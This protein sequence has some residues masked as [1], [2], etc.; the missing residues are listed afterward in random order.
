LKLI[1]KMNIFLNFTI[2][3]RGKQV[4]PPEQ[5]SSFHFIICY[6]Q[7]TPLAYFIFIHHF[8]KQ[9]WA[10]IQCLFFFV[11]KNVTIQLAKFNGTPCMAAASACIMG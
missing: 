11:K 10:A 2:D 6:K 1:S 3:C 8:I 7:V 5:F 4:A 9:A